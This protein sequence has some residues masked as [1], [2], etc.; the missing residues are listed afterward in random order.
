MHLV[1]FRIQNVESEAVNLE[2]EEAKFVKKV[3]EINKKKHR[4]LKQYLE[5]TEVCPDLFSTLS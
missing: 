1:H 3:E 2:G 5:N 4:F